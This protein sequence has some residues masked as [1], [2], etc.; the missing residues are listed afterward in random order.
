MI[1]KRSPPSS[2]STTHISHSGFERSSCCDMMRPERR[3][4]CRTSPGRGSAV[5]RTWY[6]MLKCW[7][8]TH[9][10]WPSI[11]VKASTWRYR[12]MAC[13]RDET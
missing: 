9:T 6:A 11:G 3:F 12:G 2:P 13:S 1:A 4:S 7:S 5:W 10:G 8:S